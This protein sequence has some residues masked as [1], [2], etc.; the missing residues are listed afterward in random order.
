MRLDKPVR[1]ACKDHREFREFQAIKD[2]RDQQVPRD[3]KA[4]L[5]LRDQW[6]HPAPPERKG[7]REF[8]DS[9]E[10]V[11]PL[12]RKEFKDQ[13]GHKALREFRELPDRQDHCRQVHWIRHYDT[14]EQLGW[15]MEI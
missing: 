9:K 1:K 15:L 7:N 6:V 11:D 10:T 12:V 5:V 8:K 14:T 2:Q 4:M 3:S 13:Q